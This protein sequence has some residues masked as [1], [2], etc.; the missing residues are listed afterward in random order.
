[1]NSI[2]DELPH[3]PGCDRC[4]APWLEELTIDHVL[5]TDCLVVPA[6]EAPAEVPRRQAAIAGLTVSG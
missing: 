4:V 3:C 6:Q 2:Y 5:C 1:M